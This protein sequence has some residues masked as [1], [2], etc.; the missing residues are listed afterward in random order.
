MHARMLIKKIVKWMLNMCS[1]ITA[2]PAYTITRCRRGIRN[3]QEDGI[4]IQVHNAFLADSW[5]RNEKRSIPE[6]TERFAS[7]AWHLSR[8]LV[9]RDGA[10]STS[11]RARPKC[12]TSPCPLP[13]LSL[14]FSCFD[15][16]KRSARTTPAGDY[17]VV[18]HCVERDGAAAFERR[19]CVTIL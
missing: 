4:L 19:L 15:I 1:Q 12:Q 9:R 11:A 2:I 7:T 8:E 6:S 3:R 17:G 14:S 10:I 18:R 16:W 13:C 5:A